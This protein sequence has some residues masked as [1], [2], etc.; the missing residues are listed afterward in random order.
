MALR[1][2]AA[3]LAEQL[4]AL[5]QEYR[6]DG[7]VA[8]DVTVTGA[9]RPVSAEAALT[10]YRTAQEAL[11]NARKHAPGQPVR[12]GLEFTPAEIA[13]RVVNPMPVTAGGPLAATGGQ[14]GL[15]GL[16]ER[17]ALGGGTLTAGPADGEWRVSLSIPA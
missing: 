11:T 6:A 4:S 2:D 3:P 10:A 8:F 15:T 16:R 13:I 5:A 9:P 1:D 17:A 14:Y 12:L 7:D